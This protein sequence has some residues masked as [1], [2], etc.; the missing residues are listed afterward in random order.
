MKKDMIILIID[1]LQWA[2]ANSI[3]ML[4]GIMNLHDLPLKIFLAVR[5]NEISDKEHIK[6]LLES[7]S[8]SNPLRKVSLGPLSSNSVKQIINEM[9]GSTSNQIHE[10][11]EIVTEKTKGNPFFVIQFV[12]KLYLDELLV[13]NFDNQEW[14]I[15]L[16]LIKEREYTSNVVEL[17]I[18]E[19]KEM[20]NRDD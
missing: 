20:E 16:K 2:D 6:N 15:K 12:T 8:S 18:N 13:F 17:L 3:S 14:D 19:I 10:L 7:I 9:T 1:D 4:E 5:G 11:S